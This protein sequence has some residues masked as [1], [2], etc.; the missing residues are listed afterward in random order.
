M[1]DRA[2]QQPEGR[3]FNGGM[4]LVAQGLSNAGVGEALG[5]SD[6]T[7]KR[8]IANILLKLDLPT[9]SAAA[10]LAGRHGLI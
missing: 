1:D 6:H 8:H 10:M 5:I 9:R 3:A 2:E 7:A 4:L